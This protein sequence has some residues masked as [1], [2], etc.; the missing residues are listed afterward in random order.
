[1]DMWWH[2]IKKESEEKNYIPSSV[3]VVSTGITSVV[4]DFSLFYIP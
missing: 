1:M 2:W 3:A 4:N